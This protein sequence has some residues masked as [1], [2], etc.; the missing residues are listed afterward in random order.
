MSAISPVE[1]SGRLLPAPVRPPRTAGQARLAAELVTAATERALSL[2]DL[3]TLVHARLAPLGLR[4]V[5][6]ST[7]GGGRPALVAGA[8][9]PPAGAPVLDVPL[10][11][12]GRRVGV[13]HLTADVP[14]RLDPEVVAAVAHHAA[15]ALQGCVLEEERRHLDHSTRAL[16]RLFEEGARAAGVE[17]AGRVLAGV[18]AEAFRTER[19]AVYL[20]GPDG[21]ICG[22]IGVGLPPEVGDALTDRLVGRS[23]WGSPAWSRMARDEAPQLVDDVAAVPLRPGGFVQTLG[24]RSYVSIPLRSAT[25]VLGAAVCGEVSRTRAWTARETDLAHRLALQG[26]L[27]VDSARL[28]QAERQ[29]LQELEHR[30]FHDA[31][32]GL[33]NRAALLSRLA[34]ALG[35]ARPVALLLIDLNGFKQVNDTLGHHGGD[36]LLQQVAGRLRALA[37]DGG[38]VARLGGDELAV[39]LAGGGDA[40]EL[41]RRVDAELRAPFDLE[42]HPVLISAA[43]GVARAPEHAADVTG[44][45]RAADEAMYRSKRG[46]GGP[47]VAA[48]PPTR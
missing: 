42:G 11:S 14:A 18:T 33:P 5:A 44:L 23:A 7:D 43:V 30:A 19:A 3:L 40:E 29:H 37:P 26:A 8:G 39:L 12:A 34:R 28:R 13:M 4:S 45:L 41:A 6:V 16:G 15:V 31:L 21:V 2:E 17:V 27:V 47:Q 46:G 36:L 35:G 48:L 10:R 32:T 20:V 25:G 24:L 9:A 38:T 1:P 22:V